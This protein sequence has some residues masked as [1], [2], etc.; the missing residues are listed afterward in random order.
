[1]KNKHRFSLQS[2]HWRDDNPLMQQIKKGHQIIQA[3]KEGETHH[4]YP[5]SRVIHLKRYTKDGK[6]QI[7]V[8]LES[9]KVKPAW[10]AEGTVRDALGPL[11]QRLI[12]KNAARPI[13]DRKMAYILYQLWPGISQLGS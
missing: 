5:P 13:K 8:Y 2:F 9:P 12:L 10:R 11:E 4:L 6:P 1:M 7:L 3:M